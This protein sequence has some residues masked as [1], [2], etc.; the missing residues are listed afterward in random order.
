MKQPF[1]LRSMMRFASLAVSALLLLAG[2]GWV[3]RAPLCIWY[4]AHRLVHA[5]DSDRQTCVERVAAFDRGALPKLIDCLRGADRQA[6]A[7]VRAGILGI[8]ERWPPADSR[9]AYLAMSLAQQ[10]ATL[11]DPGQETALEIQGVLLQTRQSGSPNADLLPALTRMLAQTARGTARAIHTLALRIA[12]GLSSRAAQ[13][14]LLRACRDL[15]R[16][17]LGDQAAENRIQ[18][19]DLAAQ[20]EIGLLEAVVPLLNDPVPQVRR[21]AMLAV[22]S[23]STVI[24]TDDLLP[25]LHDPDPQV[26]ILCEKALRSRGLREAHVKLGRLMTDS[27]PGVRLQ[28]LDLLRE[29]NDLEP[30]VWLRR[31]SHDPTPAVRA[32]AVRA[33][34][35][36]TLLKMTNLTDR[37][38]QMAQN[39][40]CPSVRQLAQYYLTSQKSAAAEKFQSP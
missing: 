23:A 26:R 2:I 12:L 13:P 19:I 6:C 39:D 25:C 10:F 33:A 16:T 28:V 34:A 8:A 37:L 32:A 27:R 20:P 31:L 9:R 18:A 36:Q 30:G 38:E 17:C 21:S 29:V 1:L 7:N 35:D 40:P 22:G 14:D 4:S 24:N 15:T 5:T 3:E 11:G